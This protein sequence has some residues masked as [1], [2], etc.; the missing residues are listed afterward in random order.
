MQ[1][2]G[3]DDAGDAKVDKVDDEQGDGGEGGDEEFVAPADVEEVV[4]DAEDGDGLQ[5]DD[6]REVGCQLFLY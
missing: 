6:G 4:A 2:D 3:D 5:A 1:R